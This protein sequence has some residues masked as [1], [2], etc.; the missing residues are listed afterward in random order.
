MKSL[1]GEDVSSAQVHPWGLEQDRRWCLVDGQGK[2]LTARTHP[3]LLGLTAR[4]LSA[5]TVQITDRDGAVITAD[6]GAS[7]DSIAVTL[8][9]QDRMALASDEVNAWVSERAGIAASLA[10]QPDPLLRPIDPDDGGNPGDVLSLADAAPLLL[11]TEASL[12]QLNAWTDPAV[13]PLDPVRFRPNII[14]DGDEPFAEEGW[15]GVTIDG[16]RFRV[17]MICGRCAMPTI[18]PS[19]LHRSKEPIRTLAAHRARE[20]KTWFG[21]RLT[22]LDTGRIAVGSTVEPWPGKLHLPA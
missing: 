6:M 20:N 8:Q 4:A 2:V 14:I 22:P 17:T 10:W 16:L 13:E 7:H 12:T 21:I 11:T 18:D 3:H 19:T 1:A 15:T 5:T 9:G